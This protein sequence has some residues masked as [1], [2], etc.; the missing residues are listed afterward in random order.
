[1]RE[2]DPRSYHRCSPVLLPKF[3]DN[4]CRLKLDSP[5]LSVF[6]NRRE[7]QVPEPRWKESCSLPSWQCPWVWGTAPHLLYQTTFHRRILPFQPGPD[8]RHT[9]SKTP[10]ARTG[11]EVYTMLYRVMK[12]WSYTVWKRTGKEN[13]QQPSLVIR[14]RTVSHHQVALPTFLRVL[15]SP[16]SQQTL[17][18]LRQGFL[19]SPD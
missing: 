7:L 8:H 9:W 19:C 15:G 17:L 13:E 11:R 16:L 6:S 10:M 5:N 4:G 14:H 18:I 12:Y 1:M 3:L 2:G